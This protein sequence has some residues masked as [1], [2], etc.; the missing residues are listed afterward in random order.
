ME[1]V[2]VLT[3]LAPVE[4]PSLPPPQAAKAHRISADKKRRSDLIKV[5][6]NVFIAV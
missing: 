6:I 4:V 2:V 3:V 1:D 5:L